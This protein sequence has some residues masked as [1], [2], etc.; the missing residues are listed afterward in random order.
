MSTP[1][2]IWI[3]FYIDIRY[4]YQ[5][6]SKQVSECNTFCWHLHPL[7][8]AKGIAWAMPCFWRRSLIRSCSSFFRN[9]SSSFW[10]RAWGDGVA[11][12]KRAKTWCLQTLHNAI[13]KYRAR[14]FQEILILVQ[15]FGFFIVQVIE[16]ITCNCLSIP[17][18]KQ[19]FQVT[20]SDSLKHPALRTSA[21]NK[22]VLN[23]LNSSKRI[24]THA[25]NKITTD[26]C[27]W[28]AEIKH[29]ATRR[30]HF[31]RNPIHLWHSICLQNSQLRDICRRF[32]RSRVAG[33]TLSKKSCC[34]KGKVYKMLQSH[35]S[36]P[37]TPH[38]IQ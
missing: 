38:L 32:S 21:P 30:K 24:E 11:I 17:I 25:H 31:K 37:S 5:D 23:F 15:C 35:F 10:K 22:T 4:T 9:C 12:G 18:Q 29:D 7:S 36:P 27:S 14:A 6:N 28:N 16:W 1:D 20:P 8:K 33:L 2:I 19:A 13:S 3:I 34:L 26:L